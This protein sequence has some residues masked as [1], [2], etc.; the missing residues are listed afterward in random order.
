VQV[1]KA[2]GDSDQWAFRV[3]TSDWDAQRK[4]TAVYMQYRAR[5]FSKNNL[6]GY[7]AIPL[8]TNINKHE[9]DQTRP[10]EFNFGR[11]LRIS[12]NSCKMPAMMFGPIF[13]CENNSKWL[14]V[15]APE[16]YLTEFHRRHYS[17]VR[18]CDAADS[19]VYR[20]TII[21]VGL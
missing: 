1:T 2:A 8:E 12:L 16:G 20:P 21:I 13:H 15:V 17:W 18:V 19:S 14:F 6:S 3:Q 9:L 4:G 7:S 10:F 11:E 5:A